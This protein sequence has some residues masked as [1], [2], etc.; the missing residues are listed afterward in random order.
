VRGLEGSG[1]AASIGLLLRNLPIGDSERMLN[2]DDLGRSGV[3]DE[4]RID[5]RMAGDG[6]PGGE[7]DRIALGAGAVALIVGAA[8]CLI[9]ARIV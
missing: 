2:L 9:E 4:G 7:I 5:F 3:G 6:E 1:G 8:S